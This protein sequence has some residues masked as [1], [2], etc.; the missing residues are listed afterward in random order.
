MA[1]GTQTYMG[2]AVP[3]YG[4]SLIKQ[5]TGATDVL[6]L[7][8]GDGQTGDFLVARTSTETERFV[9]ED[10]G[11]VVVTQGAAGDVGLKILRA[12]G[13]TAHAIKVADNGDGTTKQWAITSNYGML[14]RIFTT[15]PTT[16][17]TKGE[18]ILLFHNSV[19]K[20]AV[21]TSTAAD[22]LKMVRLRTKTLGRLTA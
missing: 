9:V 22:T 21:C 13:P 1:A 16:G 7:Q 20:L 19:P 2:L 11:N 18:L 12:S 4:E 10:G 3:I 5:Q 15:K 6:T 14:L 17:L 8:G